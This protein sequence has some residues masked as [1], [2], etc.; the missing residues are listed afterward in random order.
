VHHIVISRRVIVKGFKPKYN[1]SLGILSMTTAHLPVRRTLP[2]R[3]IRQKHGSNQ[4][5][6]EHVYIIH[7]SELRRADN[8]SDNRCAVI[9][10]T[11]LIP[12][13]HGTSVHRIVI[14]RFARCVAEEKWYRFV[15]S[16]LDYHISI[17]LA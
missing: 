15:P 5:C 7:Q 1:V 9:K 2:V 11:I 13:K 4:G 8:G 6:S 17:K 16:V 12:P 10:L 3:L 14:T